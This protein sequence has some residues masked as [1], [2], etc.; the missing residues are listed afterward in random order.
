MRHARLSASLVALALSLAALP[1][2]SDRG[3]SAA[4]ASCPAEPPSP[5]RTLYRQSER[6][7]V[8]RAGE[9]TRLKAEGHLRKTA[10]DV[11]ESLKGDPGEKRINVYHWYWDDNR[12][13]AGNFRKG[14]T[15]LLFLTRGENEE[16][17][18]YRVIDIRH[19]AKKLPEADL[20]VYVKRIEELGWLTRQNP[21]DR[22]ELLEWLVRCAEE[23][24]TR[25]EG[26]YELSVAYALAAE[27]D[28][29]KKKAD[30]G[31][32]DDA[33]GAEE[34][35]EEAVDDEEVEEAEASSDASEDAAE[36]AAAAEES[37]VGLTASGEDVTASSDVEAE[38]DL[39][40]AADSSTAADEADDSHLTSM[41][42][43]GA[44]VD[45]SLAALLT[46]EQKNRL[47]GALLGADKLGEGE[48]SLISVVSKWDEG[49]LVPFLIKH[50]RKLED[51][52]PYEVEQLVF[53]LAHVL[54]DRKLV[55]LAERYSEEAPYG[56]QFQEVESEEGEGVKAVEV[57]AEPVEVKLT[58]TRRRSDM[59]RDFLAAVEKRLNASGAE[60]ARR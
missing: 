10:F 21:P 58:S 54:K 52:P 22:S 47:S 51:D 50:L 24:A 26:A 39:S 6:I 20:K 53:T 1:V 29:A 12:E 17:D 9:S 19:G 5:L 3:F 18:G 44:D 40:D 33:D 38:A 31:G 48:F 41:A 34:S 45:T 55:R 56:D 4:A 32:T 8:A 42:V 23:P 57:S 27:K 59:L 60:T 16:D 35:D 15:L 14:D 30:G 49:P 2:T 43:Y 36:A 11:T 7:V 37:A 25:W 46:E 28:E 13:F